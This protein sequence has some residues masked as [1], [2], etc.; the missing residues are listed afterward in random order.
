MC[1]SWGH[2]SGQLQGT[3][4]WGGLESRGGAYPIAAPWGIHVCLVSSPPSIPSSQQW[5]HPCTHCGP[6]PSKPWLILSLR[7]L[8]T[9]GVFFFQNKVP[10]EF[11]PNLPFPI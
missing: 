8:K 3:N 11:G 1:L 7:F 10:K 5:F 9:S 6:F 2:L 4:Q